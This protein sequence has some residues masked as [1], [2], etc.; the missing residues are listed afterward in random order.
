MRILAIITCALIA[1]GCATHA[2]IRMPGVTQVSSPAFESKTISHQVLY[3][4]PK[5][6]VFSGGEQLPLTPLAEAELSVSSA[7]TLANFQELVRKQ[8]PD[9]VRHSDNSETDFKLEVELTARDKKG[10]TY[11]ASRLGTS[12]ASN[13]ATLGFAPS[14]YHI[15]A[16]FD[17][18]YR[19]LQGGTEVL[20]KAYTVS[21]RV[22]HQIGDFE[23]YSSTYEYSSQMLEKHLLLT[24]NDFFGES[25]KRL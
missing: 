7:A 12:L 16:D 19:L 25:A 5:P 18:Q 21:D 23:S 13:V 24:L 1:S 6:G 11:A 10:P 3:S 8:L 9:S 15:V 14:S 20:T 4:Q 17:V 22:K 2:D